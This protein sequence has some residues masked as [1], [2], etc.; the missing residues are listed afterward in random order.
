MP[1]RKTK[2]VRGLYVTALSSADG[3][4][5]V[6]TLGTRTDVKHWVTVENLGG[7]PADLACRG[8]ISSTHP[9]IK[10][11]SGRTGDTA[12][13]WTDGYP[14]LPD[15][16][17]WDFDGVSLLPAST[18]ASGMEIIYADLEVEWVLPARKEAHTLDIQVAP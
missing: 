13:V 1:S 10:F 16:A 18:G 14:G 4:V 3:K 5:A 9:A 11:D 7:Y 15:M 12:T 8:R 17:S 6:G 2:R